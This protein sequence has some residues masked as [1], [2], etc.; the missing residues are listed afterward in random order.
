MGTSLSRDRAY[1]TRQKGPLLPLL[2][3]RDQGL[4]V[5]QEGHKAGCFEGGRRLAT[6]FVVFGHENQPVGFSRLLMIQFPAD[7]SIVPQD[8]KDALRGAPLAKLPS[9]ALFST[10]SRVRRATETRGR[11][12]LPLPRGVL[13]RGCAGHLHLFKPWLSVPAPQ[14]F[15]ASR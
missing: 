11:P 7:R 6:V 13:R 9:Q 1:R 12:P 5:R 8:Y 3:L 10:S 15:A 4:L 14:S 2:G